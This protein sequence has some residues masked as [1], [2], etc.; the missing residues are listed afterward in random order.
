MPMSR[1]CFLEDGVIHTGAFYMYSIYN[2]YK[3]MYIHYTECAVIKF[4]PLERTC[5]PDYVSMHVHGPVRGRSA[6]VIL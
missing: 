3:Y 4:S 2:I 6:G 5:G 1:V